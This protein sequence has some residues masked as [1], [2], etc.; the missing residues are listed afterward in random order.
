MLE[1]GLGKSFCMGDIG[2]ET[3]GNSENIRPCSNH[4]VI[5]QVEGTAEAKPRG[6]TVLGV[7]EAQQGGQGGW[8]RVTER[9]MQH[10]TWEE[11]CRQWGPWRSQRGLWL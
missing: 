4:Q 6:W 9:K 3:K 10:G 8:R 5:F 11:L 1:G 2:A 7:L